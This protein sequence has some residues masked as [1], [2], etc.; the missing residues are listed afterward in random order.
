MR[1][2]SLLLSLAGLSFSS[3]ALGTPELDLKNHVAAALGMPVAELMTRAVPRPGEP[4]VD[5]DILEQG[6]NA[7][8]PSGIGYPRFVRQAAK[9]G[10]ARNGAERVTSPPG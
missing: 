5:L 9:A 1:V 7:R 10:A 2:F 3:V 4:A 8:F 6:A